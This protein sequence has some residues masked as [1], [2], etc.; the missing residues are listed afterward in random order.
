MGIQ[1]DKALQKKKFMK[2]LVLNEKMKQKKKE[3]VMKKGK[4]REIKVANQI[5][6]KMILVN[7]K[8]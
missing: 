1:K 7:Y 4:A 5:G 3:M 8:Q 2:T 6:M